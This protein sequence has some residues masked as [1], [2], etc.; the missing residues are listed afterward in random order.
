M[1]SRAL[2]RQT[3]IYFMEIDE[4]QWKKANVSCSFFHLYF[5]FAHTLYNNTKIHKLFYKYLLKLSNYLY[6]IVQNPVIFKA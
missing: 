5:F 1:G 3:E 2:I 6:F 4:L